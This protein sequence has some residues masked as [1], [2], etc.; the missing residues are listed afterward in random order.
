MSY[1]SESI[2]QACTPGIAQEADAEN[3]GYGNLYYALARYLKPQHVLVIGSGYGFAPAILGLALADNGSGKLTFVDP[4]MDQSRDGANFAHGGSGQWDTPE[5]VEARF[6]CVGVPKGIITHFKERNDEFFPQYEAR[7]LPPID[8]ALIDGA[9]DEANA[10]YDL[11]MVVKYLRLPGY[12][13][14]HD[15]THFLNR[16]PYMGVTAVVERARRAQGVEEI[17]FPGDAGLSVFRISERLD[18]PIMTAPPPSVMWPMIF[19]FVGGGVFGA[20]ARV[21][22]NGGCGLRKSKAAA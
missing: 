1:P 3:L 13:M 22:Y 15:A 16:T 8:L 17:T 19:V 7:K 2:V 18:V 4:S 20:L 11:A 5:Q 12:V 14:M 10:S 9:H 6:A 21:L